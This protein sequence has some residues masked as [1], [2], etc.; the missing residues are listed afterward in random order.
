MSLT[1]ATYNTSLANLLVVPTSD[2]GYQTVLPN[3]I[4]QAEQYLYRELDLLNTVYRDSTASLTAGNRNFSFPSDLGNFLVTKEINVCAPG[5]L[6]DNS[7]RTALVPSSMEMLNMLWPS[8]SG[9]TAPQYFA[10]V[11]Q[12]S[13]IVGPW[14][15]QSYTVEV[16]GT[17]FPQPLS[18]SNTTSLLSVYFPDLF[19]SASMVFATG[20]Q[21][22]F[23]GAGNDDPKQAV[24]W[25]SNTEMLLTSAKT[26]EARKRFS[27]HGLKEIQ[28]PMPEPRS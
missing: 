11:N 3:I 10:M 2:P 12:S 4:D 18:V 21:R 26:M 27:E 6:P 17:I 13:I 7:V 9:S 28:A 23:G 15:D 1:Y 14:P 20:Y 8:V 19:L 22:D 24:N 25:R 5:L 16:V